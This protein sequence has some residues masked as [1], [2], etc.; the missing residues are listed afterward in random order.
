MGLLDIA[1]GM[2]KMESEEK[3]KEIETLIRECLTEHTEQYGRY[4]KAWGL[5]LRDLV[6][7]MALRKETSVKYVDGG[8]SETIGRVLTKMIIEGEII[9][10]GST[11]NLLITFSLS[12]TET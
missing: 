7:Q 9:I 5:T 8:H 12:P 3:E 6:R 10:S 2:R 11:S 4:P 1:L